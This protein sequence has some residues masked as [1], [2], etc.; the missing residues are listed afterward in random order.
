MKLLCFYLLWSCTSWLW[1]RLASSTFFCNSSICSSFR[2]RQFCA[3]TLTTNQRWAP[4]SPPMRAHLVLA[5]PPDV[6]AD[7]ELLLGE[8]LLAQHVVK[9]V[10]GRIH[11]VLL[12]TEMP[13]INHYMKTL[14]PWCLVWC[15]PLW[16]ASH[17]CSSCKEDFLKRNL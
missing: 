8:V 3:A 2:F 16:P 17:P 13:S 4:S 7:V 14:I 15:L 1:R 5:P 9:L 6:P 12:Q 10:H 11:Y